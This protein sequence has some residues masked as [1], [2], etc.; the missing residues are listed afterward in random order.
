MRREVFSP[1]IQRVCADFLYI[2]ESFLFLADLRMTQQNLISI[3]ANEL[4]MSQITGMSCK[5][6]SHKL[7]DSSTLLRLLFADGGTLPREMYARNSI[8]ANLFISGAIIRI[9]VIGGVHSLNNR[10]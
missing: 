6:T 4:G 8:C 7:R 2:A 1:S 3:I 10:Q 5:C 9:I